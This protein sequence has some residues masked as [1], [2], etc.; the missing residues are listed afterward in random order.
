MLSGHYQ[1]RLTARW[2]DAAIPDH[3]AVL[4]ALHARR[5]ATSIAAWAQAHPDRPLVVVLT[6]T[7]LYRDIATDA[8]AQRSLHLIDEAQDTLETELLQQPA[9]RRGTEFSLDHIDLDKP[10]TAQEF[11]LNLRLTPKAPP[12]VTE[13][14][15]SAVD[16]FMQRERL[17]GEP[18]VICAFSLISFLMF[19]FLSCRGD[20]RGRSSRRHTPRHSQCEAS[21]G[22]G[23]HQRNAAAERETTSGIREV[24]ATHAAVRS[25]RRAA[26]PARATQLATKGMI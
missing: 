24:R 1:V 21:G 4:I 13:P 22:A 6:G 15:T 12:G 18:L 10:L 3:A 16:D 2:P 20:H 23:P 8:A 5:S 25:P 7:D 11:E 26:A 14:L 9:P 19:L 17:A